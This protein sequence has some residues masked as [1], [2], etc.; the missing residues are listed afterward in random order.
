MV[1]LPSPLSTI[2]GRCVCPEGVTTLATNIENKN[3]LRV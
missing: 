3:R 1:T 2:S